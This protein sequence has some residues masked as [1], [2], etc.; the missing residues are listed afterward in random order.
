MLSLQWVTAG[1]TIC[2]TDGLGG[3]LAGPARMYGGSSSSN[4]QIGPLG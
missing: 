2:P 4:P 3:F 1:Q